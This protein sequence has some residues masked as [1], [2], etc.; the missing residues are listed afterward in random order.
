MIDRKEKIAAE[1]RLQDILDKVS[2][3]MGG[4]AEEQ[5]VEKVQKP[6]TTFEVHSTEEQKKQ[7]GDVH[8]PW[9]IDYQPD[10]RDDW[11]EEEDV[12]GDLEL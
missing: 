7:R 5:Q 1:V 4:G 3:G 10:D 6:L 8:V 11:D 9:A 12:D 2:M